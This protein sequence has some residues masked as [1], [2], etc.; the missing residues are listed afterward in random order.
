M[1]LS[2]RGLVDIGVIVL[3]DG[4]ETLR[5]GVPGLVDV[6]L[7]G[8]GDGVETLLRRLADDIVL[9]NCTVE[10]TPTLHI[11]VDSGCTTV[12]NWA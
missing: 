9:D 7:E 5:M 11:S 6:A 10:L 2:V 4:V 12:S 8:L 3:D 1:L